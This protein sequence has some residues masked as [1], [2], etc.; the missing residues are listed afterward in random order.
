LSFVAT[1]F[2]LVYFQRVLAATT[3]PTA[4]AADEHARDNA[5]PTTDSE[6]ACGGVA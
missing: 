2:A 3:P 1:L 4:P 6:A 5:R